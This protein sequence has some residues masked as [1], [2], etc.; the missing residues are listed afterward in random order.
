MIT[1]T[2]VRRDGAVRTVGAKIGMS[3]MEAA[4]KNDVRGIDADCGGACACATCH[5][6][7]PDVWREALGER[8]TLENGMLELADGVEASSRLACQIRLA[9][10]FDGLT[11]QVAD[12]HR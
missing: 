8:T 9:A 12:V 6:Y 10:E 4:V 5:V 11:V 2:F 3:L 1:V 7:V